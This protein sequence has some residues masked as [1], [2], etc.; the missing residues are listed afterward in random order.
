MNI[1]EKAGIAKRQITHRLMICR[2]LAKATFGING[3]AFMKKQSEFS[4]AEMGTAGFTLI[5]ILICLALLT[6]LAIIAV[7]LHLDA[8]ERAKAVEATEALSEVVRLEHIR[9]VDT[10]TYTADLAELGF[11]L[12]SSLKYTELFIEVRRDAKGWSYMAFA[13]PLHRKTSDAGGWGVAQYA[14]G[15]FQASLPGT[16]DSGVASPCSFWGGWASM[17]GGRIEGEES[18]SSWT[19]STGGNRRPC[20]RNRVVF[21]GKR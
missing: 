19:S 18:L 6:I 15:K 17:E 5:E 10:G 4:S 11:Q 13:M 8:V 20:E 9:H 12:T 21:H 3:P 14:D 16:L 7:P 2:L 1:Q